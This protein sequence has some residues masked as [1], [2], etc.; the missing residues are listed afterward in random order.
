LAPLHA[1]FG[2]LAGCSAWATVF[3]ALFDYEPFHLAASAG[4]AI[5][6]P[7][8]FIWLGIRLMQPVLPDRASLA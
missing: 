8:W 6:F 5:F 3:G 4:G 7:L 1:V 2:I